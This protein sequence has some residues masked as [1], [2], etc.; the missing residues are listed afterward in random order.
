MKNDLSESE[1]SKLKDLFESRQWPELKTT[2]L[3][4]LKVF[5]RSS[6]LWNLL[7]VSNQKLN[8]LQESR[9]CLARAIELDANFSD[10]HNNL[11]ITLGLLGDS[12]GSRKALETALRLSPN[13][14]N[15]HNNM[16][17]YFDNLGDFP[18]AKKYFEKALKI[19]PDYA[20]AHHN[21]G[22]IYLRDLEF[23][24][25]WHHRNFRWASSEVC[26]SA[27]FTLAP[28]WEG[29]K[30]GNLF[31]WAEQ[32]VGDEVMLSSM[33]EELL[34]YCSKLTISASK[35]LI[36]LFKRNLST[37]IDFIDR[38]EKP[39]RD[40]FDHQAPAMN[41]A[42][43]LRPNL[44]SFSKSKSSHLTSNAA[45][46]AKIR[47]EIEE[48]ANGRKI[49]GVSWFSIAEK[50]GK[51]RSIN[52]SELVSALPKNMFLV[53]LQYGDASKALSRAKNETG[54]DIYT[55]AS[56]DTWHDLSGVFS[57]IDACDAIISI[58]NSTVHFAG[59]LGK[60]CHV[61]LAKPYDWRWGPNTLENSYWYDSLTL[62][63]AHSGCNAKSSLESLQKLFCTQLA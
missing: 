9:F 37:K 44:A 57:L 10:A 24:R 33:F 63:H 36:P 43:I 50:V 26:K 45:L 22:S 41:A 38:S 23:E 62:H 56:I 20:D 11:A 16:G 1:L 2:C 13:S 8:Q 61:L 53:N 39:T 3:Y 58:D 60:E 54:T 40:D 42:A 28:L 18:S 35:R 29:E 12:D 21:L 55:Y 31:I 19:S 59:S 30:T 47:T 6:L 5:S 34:E 27:N 51:C 4:N 52:I 25:G 46:T 14:A 49:V 15:A 48:V 7:G 32:G 17:M